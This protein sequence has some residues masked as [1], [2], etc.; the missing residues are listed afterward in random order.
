VDT[1]GRTRLEALRAE[2]ADAGPGSTPDAAPKLS[3]SHGAEQAADALLAE[4]RR[5][6]ADG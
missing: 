2:I 1:D 5:R 3:F 4:R 6:C